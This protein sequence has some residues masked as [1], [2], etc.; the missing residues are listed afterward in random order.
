MIFDVPFYQLFILSLNGLLKVFFQPIFYFVVFMVYW[1]CKNLAN[2]Q[3]NLFGHENLP[4]WQTVLELTAAGMLGGLFAS[5]LV[6]ITGLSI[7]D[8]GI[9][10]IWPLALA[11]LLVNIRFLCFAYAGGIIALSNSLF[12]WPEV[13][14]SHV[15]ALVAILHITE[16]ML[17]FIGGRFS[18][19]PV[20]VKFKGKAVGGFLLSNFWP[21]PLIMMVVIGVPDAQLPETLRMPDWWPIFPVMET[22]QGYTNILM[23]ITIAAILGYSSISLTGS[24]AAKRRFSAFVLFAYSALLLVISYLSIGNRMFGII[25]ALVSVIGHEV[26]VHLDQKMERNREPI[27][28]RRPGKYVVLSTLYD[29]PARRAGI[30]TNDVIIR[31]NKQ[32]IYDEG[33][34][35]MLA[36][37]L[38]GKFDIEI[39]R[40]EKY[41]T[42]P[43]TIE[44]DEEKDIGIIRMPIEGK[45]NLMSFEANY[46]ILSKWYKK[47]KRYRAFKN[48]T[49][50]H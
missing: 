9:K 10:Y 39:I 5:M 44:E 22:E 31:V 45:D 6:L 23:P 50:G 11:L 2:Q 37:F 16:S 49:R 25:A 1:Q 46:S 43:I 4:V 47:Y 42:L 3:K 8:L 48:K 41:L 30:Q 26:A 13:A 28:Q 35:E 20:Y 18:S 40:D 34:M 7:N 27:Y 21:L 17:V 36:G 24:P 19:L 32:Q 15:L 12:G 14:A 29:S 33:D 38:P